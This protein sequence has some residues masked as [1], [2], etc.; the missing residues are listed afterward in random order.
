MIYRNLNAKKIHD[1]GF[2][3]PNNPDLNEKEI[4]LILDLLRKDF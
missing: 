1:L 3:I 4:E 2:Y